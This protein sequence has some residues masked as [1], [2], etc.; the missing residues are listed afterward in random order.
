MATPAEIKRKL[1]YK[2]DPASI[3]YRAYL[4]TVDPANT[5]NSMYIC[6]TD[7]SVTSLSFAGDADT[8]VGSA[9]I[10]VYNALVNNVRLNQIIRPLDRLY[11]DANYGL[12]WVEVFR[13]RVY[14]LPYSSNSSKLLTIQANDVC[15]TLVKSK[16]VF[17]VG[18]PGE[19]FGESVAALLKPY[20]SFEDTDFFNIKIDAEIAS[21]V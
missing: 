12:G 21:E 3:Q 6:L 18:A 16:D 14:Q 2:V 9:S 17:V 15:F 4:L 5:N 20:K 11:I 8:P 10:S 1:Q 13:G 7:C 19:T